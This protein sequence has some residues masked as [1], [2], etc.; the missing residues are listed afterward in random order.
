MSYSVESYS[1]YV[2]YK[3]EPHIHMVLNRDDR[4]I[5]FY[6]MNDNFYQSFHVSKLKYVRWW[7]YIKIYIKHFHI[8]V[9][10]DWKLLIDY[11]SIYWQALSWD[12]SL[13]CKIIVPFYLF[14]YQWKEVIL[15]DVYPRG[16]RA[17]MPHST[18]IFSGPI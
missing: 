14:T 16:Q 11:F 4:R 6:K 2:H 5:L 7:S 9:I 17:T 18:T 15:L 8:L 13:C 10:L 3:C 1:Q 12:K